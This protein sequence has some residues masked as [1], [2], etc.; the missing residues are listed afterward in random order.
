[1]QEEFERNFT[2]RGELGA[3]V[4]IVVEGEPVVD[5]WGGVADPASGRAWERDTVVLV[6][7]CTK[8]ATALCAHVLADRGAL[9]LEVPVAAYWP[10]FGTKGKENIPVS[11]LLDHRAGLP[12]LRA[13]VPPGGFYDWDLI[14]DLLAKQEPFWEPGTRHGYHAFTM[15]WLV[16]EVVRRISGRSLGTFF[17]DEIAEPLG[18]DFWIGAPGSV[19]GRLAPSSWFDPS[20]YESLPEVIEQ[21]VADP[22][23]IS[24]LAFANTGGYFTPEQSDTREAHAAEIGASGGITNA[25]GLAAMYA[26]LSTGGA[27]LVNE[28]TIERMRKPSSTGRDSTLLHSTSFTLG[29]AK[30]WDNRAGDRGTSIMLSEN[31]FGHPGMGGSLGF[32]DPTAR[33]GFGYTMNRHGPGTGLNERGQSLVDAVY[34]CMGYERNESGLWAR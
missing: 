29:F 24:G 23:S 7:S 17:R 25:R 6:F 20:G 19:E 11:M 28:T 8:G 27:G 9:D 3:A 16:G 12:A 34:R 14:V 5:L 4:C 21:I 10:E 15:G 26:P 1:M 2:E 18:L 22:T 31:A 33:L 13:P 32:A 30:S